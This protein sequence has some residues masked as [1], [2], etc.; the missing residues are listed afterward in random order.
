MDFELIY[1][2]IRLLFLLGVPVVLA[3]ATIGLFV[4]TLQ[5]ATTIQDQSSSYTMKLIVLI[6]LL[7]FGLPIAVRALSEFAQVCFSGV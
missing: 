5:A 1:E 6:A 2:A 4:S 3:T 7:Y